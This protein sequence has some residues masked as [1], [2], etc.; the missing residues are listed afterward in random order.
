MRP[1]VTSLWSRK[2]ALTRS[3][4]CNSKINILPGFSFREE[5]LSSLLCSVL[6][7]TREKQCGT[8]GHVAT[9]NFKKIRF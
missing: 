3:R 4:A 1:S 6:R 7:T 5:R 9:T 2:W 8:E